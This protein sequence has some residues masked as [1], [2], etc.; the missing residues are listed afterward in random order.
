MTY[1]VGYVS[2][3][4][5]SIVKN[6]LHSSLLEM[7]AIFKGFG[8]NISLV[9]SGKFMC[10]IMLATYFFFFFVFFFFFF[11]FFFFLFLF[12]FFFLKRRERER[13][14]KKKKKNMFQVG[15][16]VGV[17]LKQDLLFFTFQKKK[18]SYPIYV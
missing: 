15:V 16:G 17:C 1:N 10:Y 9:F 3:L 4:C 7:P 8:A 18:T 13:E 11:F 5:I 14:E 12:L 6:S 2:F